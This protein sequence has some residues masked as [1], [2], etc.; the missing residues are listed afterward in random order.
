MRKLDADSSLFPTD[1]VHWPHV[2]PISW[3][4]FPIG[5]R[6]WLTVQNVLKSMIIFYSDECYKDS[7]TKLYHPGCLGQSGILEEVLGEWTFQY[8]KEVA[9]WMFLLEGRGRELSMLHE[10]R[11]GLWICRTMSC[12]GKPWSHNDECAF[13]LRAMGHPRR[14][15]AGR[16]IL[17][18]FLLF[19]LLGFYT[20]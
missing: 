19:I 11:A 16:D 15:E 13:I 2:S 20:E 12:V 17:L 1:K 18:S 5:E 8:R 14:V 6:G 7:R 4:F 10:W 9:S 3:N